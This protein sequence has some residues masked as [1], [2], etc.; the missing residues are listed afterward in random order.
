MSPGS[1]RRQALLAV[2]SDEP[3]NTSDLYDALGYPQLVRVGLV[4]YPAF[5]S[6]L[7]ALAAEGLAERRSAEDGSTLWRLPAGGEADR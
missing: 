5:R 7:D 6:A 1:S 2:L 4:S 3:T